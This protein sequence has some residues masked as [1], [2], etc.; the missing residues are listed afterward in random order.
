MI[1]YIFI[2]SMLAY[3][4]LVNFSSQLNYAIALSIAALPF[5]LIKRRFSY[6]LPTINYYLML[7]GIFFGKFGVWS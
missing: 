1:V 2:L 6:Y 3:T 4:P 7:L 5:I